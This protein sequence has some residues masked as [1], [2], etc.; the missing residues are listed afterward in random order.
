V[1][2]ILRST[3]PLYALLAVA[4]LVAVPAVSIPRWGAILSCLGF[5]LS[6]GVITRALFIGAFFNQV[7]PS[8]IGGD[9]WR[10][11]FCTRAGVPLGTAASSV[12]IDRL[13][14]LGAVLLFFCVTLPLL[15]QQ[16]AEGP[17]R[18][19]LWLM[20][21]GSVATVLVLALISGAAPRLQSFRLLRP[22][23]TLGLALATVLRSPRRVVL[24]LWTGLLGQAVAIVAFY[25]VSRSV[26]APLSFLECAI[27]LAPGL[28]VALVPVSLGGW[29]LREGAFVVLLGYYGVA[30]EQALI[31]SVLFGLALL[32]ATLPGLLLWLLQPAAT[33]PRLG[34]V[35]DR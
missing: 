30:P 17:V 10:I 9:A 13:V 1:E 11:W 18:W 2:A 33:R 29:G 16:I 27:T 8:S 26:G 6:S 20:T 3:D 14:G 15:L 25:L 22:L 31:I 4:I 12:L 28:L 34:G 35:A 24:L 19:L 5:A 7:L 32:A 21:A 23:A